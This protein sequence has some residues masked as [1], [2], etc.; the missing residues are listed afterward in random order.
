MKDDELRRLLGGGDRRSIGKVGEAASRIKASP[1]NVSVAIQLM[2]DTDPVISMRAADALEK[3][4][5]ADPGLLSPHTHAF[6]GDI[7]GNPQQEVRWHLLQMLP[8][9]RLTPA[10]RHEAF[11][12]AVDS[13]DH[14]SRIVV[15]DALS[16]MF[17]LSADN[18]AL[19]RIAE[20]HAARLTSSRSAAVRSRAK[21]LLSGG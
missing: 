21:R 18:A 4:T 3:A 7:A 13:L 12:I 14:H 19:R 6:L 2:R 9:L 5:R 16:A 15:A 1:S 11:A 10:E 8:R 20:Y 17:G